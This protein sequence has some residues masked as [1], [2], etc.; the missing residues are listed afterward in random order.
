MNYYETGRGYRSHPGGPSIGTVAASLHVNWPKKLAPHGIE[1]C[2]I[3]QD[4]GKVLEGYYRAAFTMPWTA[5]Y[6]QSR[7]GS[8]HPPIRGRGRGNG[9]YR[10]RGRWVSQTPGIRYSRDNRYV[11]VSDPDPVAD[12]ADTSATADP[13]TKGH[14]AYC[15]GLCKDCHSTPYRAT[16]HPVRGVR[17]GPQAS[18]KAA[19]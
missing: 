9:Q 18:V 15:K 12:V 4:D 8:P 19:R 13:S 5:T 3:R 11:A 16:P 6:L 7:A 2:D 17:P 10:D 1:P 14:A